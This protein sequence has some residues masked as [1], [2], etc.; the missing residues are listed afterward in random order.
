MNH[1]FFM[2]FPSIPDCFG[3]VEAGFYSRQRAPGRRTSGM[4]LVPLLRVASTL[5]AGPALLLAAT[6]HAGPERSVTE[7]VPDAEPS[8]QKN[9]AIARRSDEE[10]LAVWTESGLDGPPMILAVRIGNDARPIDRV[11]IAVSPVALPDARAQVASDGTGYL[12]VWADT[13]GALSAAPVR[14]DGTPGPAT[15]LSVARGLHSCVAWN[16]TDYLVGQLVDGEDTR[17]PRTVAQVTRVSRDGVP[18]AVTT[19]SGLDHHTSI[20]C[21]SAGDKTLIAWGGSST[22][23]IAGAIVNAGGTATG[24]IFIDV[25]TIVGNVAANGE[26]FAVAYDVTLGIEWALVTLEGTVTRF[27]EK[28]LP[29]SRARIAASRDGWVLAREIAGNLDATALDRNGRRTG[30]GLFT[31]SGSAMRDEAVALAGG[32]VPIAI[33]M[34]EL[35]TP[36]LSRWRV[37]TRTM[38]SG[39][40]RRRAARH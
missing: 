15:S 31:I 7:P 24:E 30:G 28:R 14:A 13:Y 37:F 29:G 26:R 8:L 27:G 12:V 10:S 32:D 21:A 17:F 35:E 6:L 33:Y 20:S 19:V 25:G 9:P 36:L 4:F 11:P 40:P 34:R 2:G 1:L 3:A 38:T 18:G 16:G 23:G 39:N 5:H 22:G